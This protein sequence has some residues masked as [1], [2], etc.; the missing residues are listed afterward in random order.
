MYFKDYLK[1]V[2]NSENIS[3]KQEIISMLNDMTADEIEE[4]HLIMLSVF[5]DD[6]DD[7]ESEV[8]ESIVQHQSSIDRNQGKLLR[9]TAKWK[10]QAKILYTKNK[11]CP[12][13]TTYSK[14]MKSCTTLNRTLSRIQKKIAS[15]KLYY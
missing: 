4:L 3:I 8:D 7:I 11:A 1:L 13:G 14:E 6:E 12:A 15:Q 2:E 5:C 9:R 10:N